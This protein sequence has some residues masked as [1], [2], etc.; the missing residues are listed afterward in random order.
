MI[1]TYR[2]AV[3]SA[4]DLASKNMAAGS[5]KMVY[6]MVYTVFL[7]SAVHIEVF[8]F[9]ILIMNKGISIQF[10]S[11]CYLLA[12]RGSRHRFDELSEEIAG[13]V[14]IAGSFMIDNST[15]QNSHGAPGIYTFT[16]SN[17]QFK[18]NLVGGKSPIYVQHATGY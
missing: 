3:S 8:S 17:N 14:K 15:I 12:D 13:V 7:V 18:K 6:A 16:D 1:V 5:V 4:L 2:L 10:G 9:M 11:W